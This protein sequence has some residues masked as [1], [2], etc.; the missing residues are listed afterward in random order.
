M[1]FKNVTQLKA[2]KVFFT[3]TF[4]PW[5][6]RSTTRRHQL[7][8]ASTITGATVIHHSLPTLPTHMLR[9]ATALHA[10]THPT[11]TSPLSSLDNLTSSYI[12]TF[13][14]LSAFQDSH[15]LAPSK[16]QRRVLESSSPSRSSSTVLDRHYPSNNLLLS[17]T[18]TPHLTLEKYP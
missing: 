6:Y 5:S 1:N 13:P 2:K 16:D 17:S 10:S 8:S 4:Q 18:S 3:P 7:E 14:P 9:N 11:T 12:R 15:Q